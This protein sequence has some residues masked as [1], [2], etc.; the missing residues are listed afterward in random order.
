MSGPEGG[1]GLSAAGTARREAILEEMRSALRSRRRRRLVVRAT[2]GAAPVL[3]AVVVLAS[4]MNRTP[5]GTGARGVAAGGGAVATSL[6]RLVFHEVGTEAGLAGRWAAPK[7]AVGLCTVV[8]DD[9]LLAE[10]QA[11]GRPAGM[12]RSA[13]HVVLTRRVAAN[14]AEPEEPA[15]PDEGGHVEDGPAGH[16]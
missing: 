5:E 10:L 6:Q 1:F 13:G 15:E 7:P 9:E 8:T 12:I 16:G 14:E 2:A 3:A 11:V 4:V